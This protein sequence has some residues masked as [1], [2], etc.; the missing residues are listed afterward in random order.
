MIARL[1]AC[2]AAAASLLC[3]CETLS[4]RNRDEAVERW[5][6]ARADVRARM[7]ESDLNEGNVDA[8]AASLAEA[9]ELAPKR[10][11][12]GALQARV[13]L[14]QGQV[15]AAEQALESAAAP[16]A[17]TGEIDYLRGVVREQQQ[18]WPE[19][20]AAYRRAL[21]ANPDDLKYLV[22][23][24]QAQLQLDQ[25]DAALEMLRAAGA[26]FGWSAAYQSVLAE[27]LE[28]GGD[29]PAAAAAW[30]RVIDAAADDA[31][32][33]ARLTMALLRAGRCDEALARL[34]GRG[35]QAARGDATGAAAIAQ[36]LPAPARVALVECLLAQNRAD[37]AVEQALEAASAAPGDA[38]ALR[39]LA[40]TC[41]AA[42]NEA[43]ALAAARHA[44]KIAPQDAM[45]LELVATLSWRAGETVEAERSLAALQQLDPG[46]AI[47]AELA[48]RMR[49]AP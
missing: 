9:V 38:R 34:S 28:Q 23:A 15:D 35:V 13:L 18:R 41:V 44:L 1:T 47:A 2:A 32:A 45:N 12:L 5:N 48:A 17:P 46:N 37:Q 22:A 31:Q 49:A 11:D 7:A 10:T 14:G 24:A 21:E 30:E 43:G 36:D 26:K 16:G 20:L 3:G 6:L 42:G 39:L 19:A 40:R 33:G 8:A 4:K 25:P 27:S 29:W